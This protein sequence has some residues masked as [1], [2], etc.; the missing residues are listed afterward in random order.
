MEE[1]TFREQNG[2]NRAQATLRDLLMPLFRHRRFMA[3]C[4][5]GILLGSIAAAVMTGSKYEAHFRVLVKRERVDPLVTAE[6]TPQS[7]QQLQPVTEEELNSEV[8]LLQS[9]DLLQK[10][11]LSTGLQNQHRGW[12]SVF[13]SRKDDS[14]TRLARAVNQLAK[15]VHVEAI[16]KTNLIDVS[17]TTA[18]PQTAYRV[19][20]ALADDYLEKHL[21]VYR[22]PGAF[23]FFQR[24]ADEY[25]ERLALATARLGEFIQ[26]ENTPDAA[27]ERDLVLKN[28]SQFDAT[29]DETKTNVAETQRRIRDIEA[30]L[31]TTPARIPTTE[32]LADN[33]P[34]LQ[35]LESTLA[36]LE[37]KHTDMVA[38]YDADYRPLTDLEL[39]IAQARMQL[40]AA[41]SVP[42]NESTTD[43]N[44]A[45]IWL[46]EELVK[47]QADLATLQGGAAAT[48]TAVNLDRHT[49]VTLGQKQLEQEDL[50]R[51]VKTAEDNYLLY[52]NK[53]EEAR[54]SDAL[55]SKRI[56]NVAIAENPTVPA[57]PVHSPWLFVLVGALL[58]AVVSTGAAYAAEY[59]DPSL[60]TADE[61][62]AVLQLEIL[63]A[64]PK[65][66][67]A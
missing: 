18:D 20:T 41:R 11:V 64:M 2:D 47:A 42:L 6:A 28:L 67:V 66:E 44:P 22:P 23:A 55:D 58:A 26:R 62:R 63:A 59:F 8:Q 51:N 34:T 29:L 35:T 56:L 10:V 15:R 52:L 24:E 61:T 21:A 38:H 46:K 19:M 53:R 17:Y 30:Q 25:H 4:F 54:I 39:Q 3:L 40:K 1:T 7:V 13:T 60:R 33:G 14:E 5:S 57:L 37:L 32:K 12:A 43:V 36:T 49:A 9:D 16:T 31:K 50:L 27:G 65:T 48:Q 45:Y